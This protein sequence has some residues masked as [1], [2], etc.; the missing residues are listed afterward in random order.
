MDENVNKYEIKVGDYILAYNSGVHEV[1]EIDEETNE[2]TYNQV[3]TI[4][5]KPVVLNRPAKC[6]M[7]H[8]KPA[9]MF[10]S[11]I[12]KKIVIYTDFLRALELKFKNG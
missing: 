4:E 2:V 5:G 3:F 6:E 1:L 9:I 12:R 8:C 7:R 10:A 11:E